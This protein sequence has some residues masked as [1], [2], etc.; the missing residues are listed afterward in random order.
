[1]MPEQLKLEVELVYKLFEQNC[2]KGDTLLG[3]IASG[4]LA[5][6]ILL[7]A[8]TSNFITTKITG[9]GLALLV[10]LIDAN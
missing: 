10:H 7:N 5:D 3:M 6:M 8:Q 9:S 4:L 2:T 1:V